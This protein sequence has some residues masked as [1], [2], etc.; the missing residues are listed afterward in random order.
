MTTQ[1]IEARLNFQLREAEDEA[2][3]KLLAKVAKYG[4]AVMSISAGES[5]ETEP[6][7]S[8]TIGLFFHAL[9]PEVIIV[10]MEAGSAVDV[11]NAIG[12]YVM[13]GK[14]LHE[15]VIYPE[16]AP[17]RSV[18][19]KYV[20]VKHYQA[21]LG[22]ALWFYHGLKRKFPVLQCFYSDEQGRFPWHKDYIRNKTSALLQLDLSSDTD[23][24]VNVESA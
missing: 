23:F 8:F 4:W 15:N 12:N 3:R 5:S 14:S 24:R 22:T 10:G 13:S 19:F 11:L 17:G 6:P 2:D 1:K 18:L 20:S 9:T 21:Y 16:L 7:F